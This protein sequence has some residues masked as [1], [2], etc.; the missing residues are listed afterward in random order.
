MKLMSRFF[1]VLSITVLIAGCKLAVIVVEGG[2]VESYDSGICVASAICIVDV[3][4]PNFSERFTATPY[5]GWYFKKWNSGDRFFC[6]GSTSPSCVLSFQGHE[7][8]N[9]VED[10]VASSELFYLMPVFTTDPGATKVEGTSRTIEVDG[11]ERIWLQ[12]KD[13]MNYSY[14]QVSEVCPN[15]AC[16]G[17]LR[18][19][20]IDL[21]GYTWASSDDVRLLFNA[22]KDAGAA[23]LGEFEITTT[24]RDTRILYAMLSDPPYEDSEY[25]RVYLAFVGGGSSPDPTQEITDVSHAPIEPSY[26]GDGLFGAWFWR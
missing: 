19:S 11:V 24:D 14:N 1:L 9:A 18:G 3:T 7:Q 15:R 8:S 16:S 4:D 21:T 10:M 17:S 23:I 6:G 20:T 25:D 5:T 22:Y 26:E 12:P 2:E 13:F